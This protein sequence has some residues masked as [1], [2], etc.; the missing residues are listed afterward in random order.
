[1]QVH[2][3]N[4]NVTL[5]SNF[6]HTCCRWVQKLYLYTLSNVKVSLT[7]LV[8]SDCEIAPLCPTWADKTIEATEVPLLSLC[9]NMKYR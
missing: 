9:I 7:G 2:Y 4:V 8:I 5:V 1:M 6:K 3:A